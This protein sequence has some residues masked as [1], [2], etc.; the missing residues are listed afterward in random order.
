VP[1]DASIWPDPV[2]SRVN[3]LIGLLSTEPYYGWLKTLV[4]YLYGSAIF[5][6][7][8]QFSCFMSDNDVTPQNPFLEWSVN[9]IDNSVDEGVR[10]SRLLEKINSETSQDV[11]HAFLEK[12]SPQ[13]VVNPPDG[14]TPQLAPLRDANLQFDLLQRIIM[15]ADDRLTDEILRKNINEEQFPFRNV[16]ADFDVQQSLTRLR[17]DISDRQSTRDSIEAPPERW[18]REM[19]SWS[20]EQGRQRTSGST[21]S[22]QSGNDIELTEI[23]VA[24]GRLRADE[25]LNALPELNRRI[26]R[27]LNLLGA[28]GFILSNRIAPIAQIAI[29]SG[30]PILL[31]ATGTVVAGA[32]P[33]VAIAADTLSL[34][35]AVSSLAILF[36]LMKYRQQIRSEDFG[37]AR[38]SS[39]LRSEGKRM[40]EAEHLLLEVKDGLASLQAGLVEERN[41]LSASRDA[42]LSGNGASSSE[43]HLRENQSQMNANENGLRLVSGAET[44]LNAL[45]SRY[46]GANA[47]MLARE[48]KYVA[49][50]ERRL[51]EGLAKAEWL[52]AKAARLGSDSTAFRDAYLLRAD[53]IELRRDVTGKRLAGIPT[54]L[55]QREVNVADLDASADM[56]ASAAQIRRYVRPKPEKLT[57]K[58]LNVVATRLEEK[59]IDLL[60]ARAQLRKLRE[61]PVNYTSAHKLGLRP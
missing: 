30:T 61:Q 22:R 42:L 10:L 11:L 7:N 45:L 18:L 16:S 52:R 51:V 25:T 35:S 33:S 27:S 13:N 39:W 5:H 34:S 58:A 17:S 59:A 26:S 49:P 20:L 56:I 50:D 54:P 40:E 15:F 37:V 3:L 19:R 2:C 12:A 8:S 1:Q 31:A 44:G 46:H 6:I 47:V 24:T 29:A 36:A 43:S 53:A 55:P 60:P 23:V 28:N 14:W 38:L 4:E 9:P 32:A 57:G 48:V 41:A 21:A